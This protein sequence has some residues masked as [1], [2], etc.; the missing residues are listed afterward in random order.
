MKSHLGKRIVDKIFL[1]GASASLRP[2]GFAVVRAEEARPCA[3]GAKNILGSFPPPPPRSCQI[4]DRENFF[5]HNG[6]RHRDQAIYF[7]DTGHVDQSQMEIYQFAREICDREKL[8]IVVDI[9]CGSGYKLL[10]YLGHLN[11]IGVDVP[12]TC[13][14]LKRKYPNRV[15][16]EVDSFKAPYQRVD[17]VIASDVIEHLVNPDS[18]MAMIEALEPHYIILS[19]P[20]R[21][22]LRVGTYDGPPLNEAHIR[23]WNFL[24]FDA[25]VNEYFCVLEHFIACAPQATQCVLCRLKSSRMGDSAK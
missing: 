19:T 20:D 22:L 24:E 6:Y 11:T 10:K 25:Y 9:G 13:N 14:W 2:L 12:P 8:S 17:L 15:W 18:L 4:G 1:S 16:K 21:D 23:E 5:I 7:N 3:W